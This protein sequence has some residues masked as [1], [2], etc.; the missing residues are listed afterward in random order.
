MRASAIA[1]SAVAIVVTA[2]AGPADVVPTDTSATF[3]ALSVVAAAADLSM[4]FVVSGANSEMTCQ[5]LRSSSGGGQTKSAA[6]RP[7]VALGP[8]AGPDEEDFSIEIL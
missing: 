3:G 6:G 7:S 8:D 5:S 1:A 4:D 2:D